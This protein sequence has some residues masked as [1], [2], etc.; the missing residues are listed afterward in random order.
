MGKKSKE[1]RPI[2]GPS[3][4]TTI[5]RMHIPAELLPNIDDDMRWQ[6]LQAYYAASKRSKLRR[7]SSR[8]TTAKRAQ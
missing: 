6:A 5:Q 4:V 7:P 2:V 1:S 8:H 3:G